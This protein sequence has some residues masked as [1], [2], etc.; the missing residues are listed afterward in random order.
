MNMKHWLARL[1]SIALTLALTWVLARAWFQSALSERLWT[2][3]NGQFDAG[4]KPGLASDIET[5]LVLV[6]SLA[7][8]V[9]AVLLLR[10]CCLRRVR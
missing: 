8:S 6:V 2:W 4:A 5:V 10:R 3:I 7:L 1:G 9:S